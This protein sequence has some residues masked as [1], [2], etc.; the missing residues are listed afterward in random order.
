MVCV[1]KCFLYSSV[2]IA[3][4]VDIRSRV[5]MGCFILKID[6]ML[7]A[8]SVS[9]FLP[10]SICSVLLDAASVKKIDEAHICSAAEWMESRF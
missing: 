9:G 2:L 7:N 1:V 3:F 8:V 10:S 4:I 6:R 5:C